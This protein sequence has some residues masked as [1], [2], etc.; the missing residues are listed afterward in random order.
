MTGVAGRRRAGLHPIAWWVWALGLL[1]AAT[2]TTDPL[3]LALILAVLAFAVAARRTAAPWARAFRY[4]LILALSVIGL[5]VLFRAVF[6]TGAAAGDHI[7]F[8]LPRLQA[9]QWYSGIGLG[10]P[11]P[12]EGLLSAAFAGLQLATLLCCIGA[13]NV[14]ANPRRALRVLPGALYELGVAVVVALNMAPQLI[15]SVQRVRRARRLRAGRARG[16]RRLRA[17]A[18]PVLEDAFDR[19]LQLAAGMDSRG[20]GRTAGAP[21]AARRIVAGLLLAGMCG[22]CIGLYGLLDT[23]APRLLGLPAILAGAL[24]CCL[25]LA[26]GGRRVRRS[27]YRPDIWGVRESVVAAGGVLCAAIMFAHL[28]YDPAALTPSVRPLE[29]P[30]LPVLPAAGILLAALAALAAP[31]PLPA[32][33]MRG[34]VARLA[35][36]AQVST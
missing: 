6:A 33:R 9:P 31:V 30:A 3:L 4:Y 7:L 34:G 23:G 16:L 5:R 19:S 1:A 27:T 22:L 32:T 35:S 25:G 10:G 21:R 14:L 2:R 12:L 13:A 20:Y 17:I 29:W 28:G 36:T 15:E 24:L 11:V 8:T 18:V 26:G